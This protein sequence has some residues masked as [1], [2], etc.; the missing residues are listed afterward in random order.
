MA[1]SQ[2]RQPT[3][4]RLRTAAAVAVPPLTL[5]LF[6]ATPAAPTAA[7]AATPGPDNRPSSVTTGSPTPCDPVVFP[8]CPAP[9]PSIIVISPVPLG[10]PSPEATPSYL[11]GIPSP[12]VDPGINNGGTPIPLG[13]GFNDIPSPVSG[14][15]VSARSHNSAPRGAPLP[16]PLL[17]PLVLVRV[18]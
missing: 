4:S 9:S 11:V 18:S 14:S 1:T 10:S 5:L 16:V 3:K 6:V 8:E 13:G 17:G 12:S 15:P 2:S 7:S